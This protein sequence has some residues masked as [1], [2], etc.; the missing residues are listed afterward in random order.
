MLIW[1]SFISSKD[2]VGEIYTSMTSVNMSIIK[3]K[4]YSAVQCKKIQPP[5]EIQ[6]YSFVWFHN[7]FKPVLQSYITVVVR[8]VSHNRH[9]W[10][11]T[12]EKYICFNHLCRTSMKTKEKISSYNTFLKLDHV[13]KTKEYCRSKAN[14]SSGLYS[15][16][17]VRASVS[18]LLL[19]AAWY[20]WI[21][22][23]SFLCIVPL[24]RKYSSVCSL[25]G[26]TNMKHTNLH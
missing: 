12:P 16:C 23:A 19:F 25:I 21:S 13:R 3:I 6:F 15:P 10:I 22:A 7:F 5:F 18:L 8:W 24:L 2:S 20:H 4:E 26:P 9:F 17:N 14:A 1:H 11:L